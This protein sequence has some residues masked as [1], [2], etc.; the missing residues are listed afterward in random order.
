MSCPYDHSAAARATQAS[1][2]QNPSVSDIPTGL[3]EQPKT[4]PRDE[5]IPQ[6]PTHWF[7]GNLSEIDPSFPGASFWRLAEIYGPIYKLDFVKSQTLVIS[8]YELINDACDESRFEKSVDGTL[9]EVR[10]LLGDGVRT[11]L[12][13]FA[14]A[15]A[16]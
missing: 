15:Y 5:P 9:A 14:V 11:F 7:T 10:A 4:A 3:S 1:E 6:P 16:D 8:D 2:V 13:N 12:E